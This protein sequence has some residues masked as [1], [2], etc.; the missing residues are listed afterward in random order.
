MSPTGGGGAA[1]N[2]TDG[3]VTLD[4]VA[5]W[6]GSSSGAYS[7]TQD[8]SGSGSPGAANHFWP[9]VNSAGNKANVYYSGGATTMND[10]ISG[11]CAQCHDEWHETER[12][13][14]KSGS[15]WKRHPVK[16]SLAADGS[17]L[18]GGGVTI[19]D[20]DWYSTTVT[21][22][23]KLPAAQDVA[24]AGLNNTGNNAYFANNTADEVMC[25][26]CHF[27]HGGPYYDNLRWDY[28][29]DVAAGSQTA[30]EVGATVGCQ[31]CH[32]R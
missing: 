7:G 14:N 30:T 20:F 1:T 11:W 9:V 2:D 31:Q 22:N 18:S 6:V 13:G 17:P 26:S 24:S 28:L 10:G 21:A 3:G 12:P 32:N 27:A 25:L 29:T 16:N 19:V 5:G 15:D 8:W 23:N 4:H